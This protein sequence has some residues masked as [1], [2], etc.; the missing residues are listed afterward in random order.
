MVRLTG[1]DI[2]TLGHRWMLQG[3]IRDIERIFELE[4]YMDKELREILTHTQGIGS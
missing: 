2:D 3:M 1:Q 4:P